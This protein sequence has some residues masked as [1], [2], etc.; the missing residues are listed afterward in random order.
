MKIVLTQQDLLP[1]L[2][3]SQTSKKS[4]VSSISLPTFCANLSSSLP[5]TINPQEIKKEEIAGFK[6][7]VCESCTEI[8]IETQYSIDV[9]GKSPEVVT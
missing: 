3:F 8:V 7:K 9:S 2:L 1:I 6:A 4:N 5:A